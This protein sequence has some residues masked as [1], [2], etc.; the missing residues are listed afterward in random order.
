MFWILLSGATLA[1]YGFVVSPKLREL[2]RLA[3]IFEKLDC[4]ALT[5]L[6]K[7]KLRLFGLKTW[8]IGVL[9]VIVA[10]LPTALE[11]L[12][13]VDYN[14]FFSADVALKI[15]GA[16]MLLMTITHI[17]GVVQAAAIEPRRTDT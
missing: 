2:R 9:G 10:A 12:R 3:G 6:Q 1:V 5:G 11:T 16:I 15:S 13:L 17:V 14:A 7:V 4:A 8:L